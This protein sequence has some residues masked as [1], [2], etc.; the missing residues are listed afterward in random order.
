MPLRHRLRLAAAAGLIACA[1]T[2]SDSPLATE[3]S[4]TGLS[5]ATDKTTYSIADVGPGSAGIRATLTAA[6]DKPYYAK[7]G[8]AFNGAIDQNPIYI[9]EGT[10]GVVERQSGDTWV[11]ATGGILVEGVREVVLS[12]GK[13]YSVFALLSTPIQPGT[14]RLTILVSESAGGPKTLTVRSATFEVR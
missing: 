9:A 3:I 10:D 7:L 12:P 13:T 6:P 5:L 1:S 14:Y 4:S 8:D 11:K 2:N